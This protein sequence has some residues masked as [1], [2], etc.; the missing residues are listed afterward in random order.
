MSGILRRGHVAVAAAAL[1]AVTGA[2]AYAQGPQGLH[3]RHGAQV[4]QVIAQVKDKL[5]LNSSQQVMWDNAMASTKAARQAGRGER[6]RLHAAMKAELAKPEPDLAAAAAIAD[7]AQANGQA[8]RN[9]VRG[10]W[11][12]LYATFTPSQKQVVRDELA[13][14]MERFENF[15]AKMQERFGDRK[16]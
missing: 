1:F 14:R 8:L 2:V 15:R 12:N 4:E 13:K 16:G 7:Q 5:A 6:E 9:Q 3:G 10:E 11:L